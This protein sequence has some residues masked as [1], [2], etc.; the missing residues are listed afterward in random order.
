MHVS[1]TGAVMSHL[2]GVRAIMKDIIDTLRAADR[3]FINLSPGNPVILPEMAALWRD[4]THQLLAKQS[5][6]AVVGRY[7]NSQGYEPFIEAVVTDFNARYGLALTAQNC[8][9]TPGSQSIFFFA[10]NALSGP[11]ADG[12]DKSFLLP[13]CPDYTGYGGVHLNPKNVRAIAPTVEA[14]G[15]THRMKYHIDMA[16]V[17]DPHNGIG[18][19]TGAAVFSR[20]CNPSGNVI[21]DEEVAAIVNHA[22]KY[23]VPVFVDSAYAPPY[24]ALNFIPMRAHFGPGVVHCISFSKSGLPGERVGVAIGDPKIVQLIESF[25]TNACIHSSRFGQA[26]AALAISSGRLPEL[27][28]AVIRPHYQHKIGLIGEALDRLMPSSLP[29]YLHRAEGGLFAWL[30]LQDLPIRD[31]DLYQ[32]LKRVGVLVVPGSA[33]FPGLVGDW[34]HSRECIRI[35][36]TASVD[37]LYEGIKRIAEVVQAIYLKSRH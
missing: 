3:P 14:C 6:D 35:S 20:P 12:T 17:T 19:S 33:F 10:A 28:Q 24:P 1:Q 8:V 5:F 18:P 36:L 9:V 13:N 22:A 26:I 15:N 21:S 25:Q 11:M 23:E 31:W 16:Q 2:T 30:W 37:E 7:G 27:A 32:E 34:S 4:C 29:W